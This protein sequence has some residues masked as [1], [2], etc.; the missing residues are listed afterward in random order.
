MRLWGAAAAAIMVL[1]CAPAQA[2]LT[3]KT[4]NELAKKCISDDQSACS[5]FIIAS[6]EALEND[7]KDRGASSCLVGLPRELTVKTFVRTL[8]AKYAYSDASASEAIE[9]IYKEHCAQ[10]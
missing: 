1:A 5:Q 7:R 2:Q 6:I 10:H 4:A 3:F 8:L 9:A